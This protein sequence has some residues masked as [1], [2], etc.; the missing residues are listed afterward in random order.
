MREITTHR[1]EGQSA[2][3]RVFAVDGPGPG[4]ASHG[5]EVEAGPYRT[6]VRFQRGPVSEAGL[7]GVTNEAL[8]AIVLDR[9]DGFQ[10]GPYACGDN[11]R[12]RTH[13]REALAEL[14]TRTRARLARG[15]EGTSHR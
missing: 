10:S 9:L 2:D 4:G 5:Y 1:V 6:H 13:I 7:N 15:V 11:E 8:L 12:A 14:Q 3:V